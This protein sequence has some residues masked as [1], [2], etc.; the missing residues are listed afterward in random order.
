VSSSVRSITTILL[1]AATGY[2]ASAQESQR[3]GDLPQGTSDSLRHANTASIL[4]DRNLNTFNWI[5]RL[6]L[7]TSFT[8]THVKVGAQILANIIQPEP[9]S[10]A[11]VG[12]S[13]STQGNFTFGIHEP[14][15]DVTG[16]DARWSSLVFADS[17]GIGLSNAAS[18]TALLGMSYMPLDALSL[19]PL[20]GYRWDRQGDIQDR[21]AALGLEA[22]L[23]PVDLDGYRFTG[24]GQLHR[25]AVSPRVLENH[26]G[27]LSVFKQ[28]GISS[29]DSLDL[30]FAQTRREFYSRGDSAIESRTDRYFSIAN[31][32]AFEVVNNVMASLFVN[33]GSRL[34]DKDERTLTDLAISPTSFNTQIEEFR[35]DTYVQ[36]A[37]HTDD[38]ATSAL[39]RLGLSERSE[40]HRAK[41]PDDM[42]ANVAVLFGERNRQEQTKDNTA[43]RVAF[44]GAIALPF[45]RSTMFLLSGSSGILRYDTP[46]DLN[47]EDRDELLVVLTLGL[48]HRF[49][50]SL[51]ALVTLDGTLSHLVYLLK[52]RSANNNYNRILRLSPRTTWRPVSWFSTVNAFEVLAN[53][54]VYDFEQQAAL[55]RSFSYRQF[56]LIDSTQVGITNRVGLDFFTYLKLY[57]RGL[58][59]WDEFRERT[60]NS[61]VDR[62]F[63]LQL[64]FRPEDVTEFAVGIRYFS[65]SRYVFKDGLKSPDSF[66]SSVGPTCAIRWSI[67]PHSRLQ[68]QGWYERRRQTDGSLRSLAS[69]TMHLYLHL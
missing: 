25:D 43:D 20:G 68:F 54:T 9:G 37:Y 21:G 65:Q 53:Y 67:G 17:R 63:A 42:P 6:S 22:E 16:I 39:I 60:E 49:T 30:S 56:S 27:Q 3:E 57:E 12:T 29:H 31:M 45:S 10:A 50:S 18:H 33:V 7:D 15:S 8:R 55:V 58:L 40:S 28:F 35:L 41:A 24:T 34:L 1:I 19:T 46:S 32:L 38:N 48:Q 52:E 2:A 44:T 5:G 4:F 13:E 69:M 26:A 61:Y 62:T 66:T 51:E 14:L 11:G 36:L 64:R 23:F 47:L 59:N